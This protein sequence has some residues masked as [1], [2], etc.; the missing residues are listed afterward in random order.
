LGKA[1]KPQAFDDSTAN[2]L[3]GRCGLLLAA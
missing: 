1:G 3:P 2:W